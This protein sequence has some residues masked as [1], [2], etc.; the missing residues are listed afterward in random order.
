MASRRQRELG[1]E[2]PHA[3]MITAVSVGAVL[4]ACTWLGRPGIL[5]ITV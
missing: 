1:H 3:V 5:F 4:G 2:V